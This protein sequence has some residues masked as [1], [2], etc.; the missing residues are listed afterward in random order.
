MIALFS[1]PK[2]LGDW[3]WRGALNLADWL[4]DRL[5]EGGGRIGGSKG[6]DC[7]LEVVDSGWV[8]AW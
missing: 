5:G 7:C 3:G 6:K 4:A 8:G 1:K 2:F